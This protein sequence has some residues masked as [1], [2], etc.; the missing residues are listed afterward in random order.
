MKFTKEQKHHIVQG[1][2]EYFR[3][4]QKD[5]PTDALVGVGKAL[6]FLKIPYSDIDFDKEGNIFII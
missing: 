1:L 5:T 3:I 2:W 6:Q 4:E